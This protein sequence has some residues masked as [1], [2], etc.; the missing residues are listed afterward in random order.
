MLI[1]ASNIPY[2]LG[3]RVCSLQEAQ[4]REANFVPDAERNHVKAHGA[5]GLGSEKKSAGQSCSAASLNY[6]IDTVD[7]S[8]LV[9]VGNV[10]ALH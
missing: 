9:W 10:P 5:V 8:G 3:T 4:L 7:H 2:H 1:K 6:C